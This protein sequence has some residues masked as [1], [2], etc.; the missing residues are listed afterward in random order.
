MNN[1]NTVFL[2]LTIVSM[3]MSSSCSLLRPEKSLLIQAEEQVQQKQY[4]KA[5][6][7]YSQHIQRR[8]NAEERPEWENPYFYLLMIGDLYLK[9]SAFTEARTSYEQAFE[10]GIEP[11]LISDRFRAYAHALEQEKLYERALSFLQQYR[12]LDPLLF[13]AMLDRIA[14]TLTKEETRSLMDKEGNK[15]ESESVKNN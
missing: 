1:K 5:R 15:D 2:F 10:K 3:V 14:K 8:L 11:L 7:L 12:S 9:E 13:D 6:K 4:N